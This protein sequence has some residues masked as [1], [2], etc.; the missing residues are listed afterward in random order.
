MPQ[1]FHDANNI[2]KVLLLLSVRSEKYYSQNFS[3]NSV[4]NHNTR[5]RS[6]RSVYTRVNKHG[7][8]VGSTF[9]GFFFFCFLVAPRFGNTVE[10]GGKKMLTVLSH[11]VEFARI[12]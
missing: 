2:L 10:K 5:R 3:V 6:R 8:F 9:R 1:R 12:K 7:L 11:C 4:R